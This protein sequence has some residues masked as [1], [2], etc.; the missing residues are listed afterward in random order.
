MITYGFTKELRLSLDEAINV[1]T[2]ALQ[3]H[4]I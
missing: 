4:F 3:C 2:A 1:T